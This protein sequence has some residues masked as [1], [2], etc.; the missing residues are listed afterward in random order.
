MQPGERQPHAMDAALDCAW[1]A[2]GVKEVVNR[3][4]MIP[5]D[6]NGS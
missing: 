2:P 1:Q 5:D 4:V 3:I 6:A